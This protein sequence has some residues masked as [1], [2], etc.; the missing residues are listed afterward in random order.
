[1]CW[2]VVDKVIE[3]LY[4]RHQMWNGNGFRVGSGGELYSF[5]EV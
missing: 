3:M 4:W 1:M 5:L 2:V